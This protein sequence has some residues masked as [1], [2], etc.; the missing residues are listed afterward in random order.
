MNF[1][2]D[3]S[4]PVSLEPSLPA[5][6]QEDKLIIAESKALKFEILVKFFNRFSTM[7]GVKKSN[8]VK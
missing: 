1:E 5:I 3:F 6:I 7:R 2:E 8:Y 4:Q